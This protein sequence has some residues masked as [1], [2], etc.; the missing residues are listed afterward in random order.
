MLK[1]EQASKFDEQD[2]IWR[3]PACGIQIVKEILKT[4]NSRGRKWECWTTKK[5]LKTLK[6]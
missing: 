6:N 3:P 2:D 4:E 1:R 5:D